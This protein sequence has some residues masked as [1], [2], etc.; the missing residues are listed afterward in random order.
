MIEKVLSRDGEG[1]M[2][3]TRQWEQSIKD[4]AQAACAYLNGERDTP[5]ESLRTADVLE[6]IESREYWRMAARKARKTIR[7]LK[8]EV[9]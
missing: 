2:M 7:Q 3:S 6:L 4:Y 5:P 1:A 8:R 9:Q